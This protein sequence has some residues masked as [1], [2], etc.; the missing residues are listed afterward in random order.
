M[1]IIGND[2]LTAESKLGVNT[3]PDCHVTEV[4]G[5]TEQRSISSIERQKAVDA[6]DDLLLY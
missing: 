4:D 5:I 1:T 3:G 2:L 6:E